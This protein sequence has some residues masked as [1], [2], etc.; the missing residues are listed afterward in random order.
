MRLVLNANKMD[1]LKEINKYLQMY[2]LPRLNQVEKGNMNLLITSNE[3]ESD[4]L[5]FRNKQKCKQNQTGSQ[6]NSTEIGEVD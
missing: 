2:N 1:N 3:T 5:K 6:V 4:N